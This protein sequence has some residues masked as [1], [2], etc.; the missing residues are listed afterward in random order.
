MKRLLLSCV[1]MVLMLASMQVSAQD[2][3]VSGRVTS[4]EDGSV[5]PGVSVVLKGT[6]IGTQTDADGRYSISIPQAGGTLTFSFIS[7]KTQDVVVTTQSI[8]DVVMQ[9]DNVQLEE[10]VITGYQSQLK[11]EITGSVV[12]VSGQSFKDLPVQSLDRA[13]QGRVAGAQISA[14]SGQP[15]GA[16]NIRIRGISSIN[17]GNNPLIIIDGVQVATLGTTTQGSANALNAINPNDIEDVQVLKDAASAAIYG[18]QAANG[19]IVVTTKSGKKNAGKTQIDISM[20]EGIVQPVNLYDVLNGQQYAELHAEAEVNSGLDPARPGGAYD[21]FGDPNDPESIQNYDWVKAL[22]QDA[23]FRMYDL[24]VRGG[25]QRTSFLFSGSYNKQEGQVIMSDWER[26]TGRLNLS[27]NPTDKISMDAKLSIAY[28]R[29]FGSI[30]DGNFVNGPWMAGFAS[31]PTSPAVD[32][33]TGAYNTYP[34]G[35]ASGI[36]HLARYNILQ[37]VNEEVRLGRTFQTVSSFSA[38]YKIIPELFISGFVGVDFSMNRDDN[39][40]PSTIPA[41]AG[42]GGSALVNNRRTV[43]LN[44]NYTLNYSKTFAEVHTV[45]ALVGYEYKFEER[46]GASLTAVG[47]ANPYFRLPSQGQPNAVSGFWNEYK[48]LGVFVKADYDFKDKYLASVT[49]RR[50]GHSRFGDRNPYGTF[51]AVSA[52]WRISE[53]SFMSGIGFIDD[54]KIK[55]GYGILGNAEIGDFTTITKFGSVAQNQYLGGSILQVTQLGNDRISWEEEESINVGVDFALFNNRLFGSIEAWQTNNKDLLFNVPFLQSSGVRNNTIV[56]NV[57]RMENKGIDLEVGGVVLDRAGFKWTSKFNVGFLKNEVTALYNGLDTLFSGSIPTLI[58]GQPSDFNYLVRYAGVNPANGAAMVYD[59]NGNLIYNPVIA[60]ATVTGSGIPS[61]YGGWTNTFTYKGISLDVFF[62]YQFGNEAF[63]QDLYNLDAS[64]SGY[65]NQRTTQLKRWQKP[66]DVTNVPKA[67]VNHVIGGVAQSFG[68][69]GSTRYQSD[70]GYIRL[71][72]ITLAYDLPSS[73][74]SRAGFRSVRVYASA[75]NLAT[76][77]KFDGIDPEVVGNNNAN[78]VSS[79][80]VYPLGR[81]MSIGLNI[82]I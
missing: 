37:G 71:K 42:N 13:L 50:D 59:R 18:A 77:T 20:Q 75:F 73:L 8:I 61:S 47:F 72:S 65:D 44:T 22:F 41:F 4:A 48:R 58:V 12:S 68:F 52:G 1:T 70:G 29:T 67:T 35:S 56:E 39:Q 66:G 64:G 43:N 74:L 51:Y 60:D 45:K 17:A 55:A 63:N 23:R 30:A 28:N 81:Q 11:R 53:E 24:S 9:T 3:T 15:G 82:G 27:H 26:Y 33:E 10:A 34:T 19:V 25:D 57:G 38:T 31:M 16:L 54:L 14:A 32:P 49:A 62:Q 46:E 36:A 79:Y 5:L 21:L 7:L 80:G 6:A 2:R 69:V 76:W 40:R 78:G